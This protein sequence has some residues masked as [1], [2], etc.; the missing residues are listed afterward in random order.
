MTRSTGGDGSWGQNP[1]QNMEVSAN[2]NVV[3]GVFIGQ[4]MVKSQ[5]VASH[6][7]AFVMVYIQIVEDINEYTALE[8]LEGEE[9]NRLDL[10]FGLMNWPFPF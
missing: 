5:A 10:R 3:L 9:G 1:C 6:K 4:V 2:P 8:E 7:G